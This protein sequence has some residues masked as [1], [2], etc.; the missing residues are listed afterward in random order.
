MTTIPYLWVLWGPWESP[1]PLRNTPFEDNFYD[2]QAR[3]MFHGHLWVANG[4][5]GIEGFFHAGREYTYFGIFPSIMRMPILPGHPRGRQRL[6][7][8]SRLALTAL[9]RTACCCGG[10]ECWCAD[11]ADLGRSE[12]VASGSSSLLP[13]GTVLL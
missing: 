8:S 5:L 2:L 12:A 9:V 1:S 13:G 11:A 4:S 7:R 10:S 6:H 3:A